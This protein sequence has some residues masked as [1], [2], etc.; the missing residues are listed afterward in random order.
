MVQY[1]ITVV[2]FDFTKIHSYFLRWFHSKIKVFKTN[3]W[4]RQSPCVRYFT[5]MH[6][7][8]L[9]IWTVKKI[10]TTCNI[11]YC[12]DLVY[13]WSLKSDLRRHTVLD[14]SLIYIWVF[15]NF[16]SEKIRHSVLANLLCWL[17]LHLE[18]EQWFKKTHCVIY[19]TNI[20]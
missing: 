3:K 14:I 20:H 6:L 15:R 5:N 17:G 7:G 10:D 1:F 18:I 8:F 2:C 13:I 16:T 12:V 9:M 4:F 11:I 19:F